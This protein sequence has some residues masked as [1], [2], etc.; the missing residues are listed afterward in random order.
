MNGVVPAEGGHARRVD[1]SP[2]P[3]GHVGGRELP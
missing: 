1:E 2:G 3:S